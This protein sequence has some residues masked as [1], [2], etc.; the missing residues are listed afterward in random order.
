MYAPDCFLSFNR[1]NYLP[2]CSSM[3]M[4]SNENSFCTGAD[5]GVSRGGA[6]FQKKINIFVNLFF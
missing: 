5:L 3:I 6:D 1:L 2:R 4:R